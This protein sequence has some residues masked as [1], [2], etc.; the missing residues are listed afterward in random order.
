[1][2]V[3]SQNVRHVRS[4]VIARSGF[5]RRSDLRSCDLGVAAQAALALPKAAHNVD[6]GL[7]TM[8]R[9]SS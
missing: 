6:R 9:K 5:L 7:A 3:S 4:T 8:C 1:M 2:G